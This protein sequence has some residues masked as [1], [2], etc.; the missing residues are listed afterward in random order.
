MHGKRDAVGLMMS[1]LAVEQ[2]Q[3]GQEA[4]AGSACSGQL[5]VRFLVG[6]GFADDLSVENSHLVRADNQM[7]RM[8]GSE[9]PGFFQ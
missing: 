9:R 5:L 7:I 2:G 4:D 1:G 8:A 6:V 3:A